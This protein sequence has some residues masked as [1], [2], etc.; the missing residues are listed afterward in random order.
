MS[1]INEVLAVLKAQKRDGGVMVCPFCGGGS[2]KR[3]TLSV[4][5]RDG[6]WLW[7]CHRATCAAKGAIPGDPRDLLAPK[8]GTAFE[9]RVLLEPLRLPALGEQ[10][11]DRVVSLIGDA[12]GPFAA[13]YGLR[14]LETDPSVHA[15]EVCGFNGNHL[16]WVTRDADKNVKTW[17]AVDGPFYGFFRPEDYAPRGP[18]VLVEDC[19]SAALLAHE[20]IPAVSLMGTNL[21][22]EAANDIVLWAKDHAQIVV[23]LD[24]DRAGQLGAARVMETLRAHG[25]LPL[26]WNLACDVNRMNAKA[27][28]IEGDKLRDLAR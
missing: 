21:S 8:D 15:W 4:N 3:R 22:N 19:L 10:I 17:R 26:R 6:V 1:G 7:L 13:R 11:A 9:P 16:G 20:G 28:E 18:L 12:L 24:P 23:A 2:R 5:L 14:V 25:A 27:R